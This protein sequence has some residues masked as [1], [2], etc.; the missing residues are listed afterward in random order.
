MTHTPGPW[1]VEQESGND[2]EAEVISAASRTICWTADTW[3]DAR[4]KAVITDEDYANGVLIAAAPDLLSAL[5]QAK[6]EL[7]ALY[8]KVYPAD[9][10]DNETTKVIDYAIAVIAQA[11]GE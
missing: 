8:E 9:E 10:A 1:K 4:E 3:D 5:R 7:I 6:D 2:G 11:G